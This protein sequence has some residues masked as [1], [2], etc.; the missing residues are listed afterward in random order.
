MN[1]VVVTSAGK[2]RGAGPDGI[3]CF[4]GIPFA[5]P[6]VGPLRFRPPTA[7]VAWDGVRDALAF[8]TAPPQLAPAPGAPA[9]WRPGDGLDCL[10]VNVW[11]PDPG[12]AGLPVT[13]WI[14]GGLWKHG[15]ASMPHYDA[16][17]LAGSGVVVVTF[18]Y[19]V[20]FEGFGHLPGVPDNCGLHDQIAALRWVRDNIGAFG[21]DSGN[22]TVF[23]QSAGAASAALLMAAPAARGLF[24]RAIA[25]SIPAGVR[26]RAEAE[27]ITAT[28]ARAA[29]VPATWDGLAGLP[30][31]ALL[32]V[33]DTP[34]RTREDGFSAFGPV[35]DGD[36]VTGQPWAALDTGAGRDVDLVC[37]F[38]HEEYRG[39]GP[40]PAAG[41]DLELV[42]EAVGLG[43]EAATAYRRAHP[44]LTDTDLFT[45]VLSDALVRMPTTRVA[46]AHARA[47]G[48]TWLYDFA[49]Q[50][51]TL[52]AAHGIDVPF[53]FGNATSR[54]A[55]RFLGSPSP[56]D[57]A[58]LS[59]H[60]RAAW[61]AFAATGD[62]GWPRFTLEQPTTRV[63]DLPPTDTAYPLEASRQIWEGDASA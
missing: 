48:R 3:S 2:V 23:G 33:Q 22:V 27:T 4:R 5:A 59:G 24:R 50:G 56:A 11:T 44:G 54:F 39:Q 10:T 61:T 30:P 8:G 46:R 40:A 28:I 14:Y 16:G 19:R 25:Q 26:T 20:G 1:P 55:A 15:A 63:W 31:E 38:T 13:V 51:P 62:P 53:V 18:N 47:G 37:G 42:T 7:P 17:R 12:A 52:G 45:V 6:P 21:G 57:F 41:V 35:I 58:D 32:A 49:W 60:L 36:L 34:L 9:M 43:K 29:G